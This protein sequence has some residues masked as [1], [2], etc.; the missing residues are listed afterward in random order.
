LKQGAKLGEVP[1]VKRRYRTA[2]F[3]DLEKRYE[4]RATATAGSLEAVAILVAAGVG[5]GILPSHYV[6]ALPHAVFEVVPASATPLTT[7]FYVL[8]RADAGEAPIVA[9][10]VRILGD[11]GSDPAAP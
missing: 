5:I 7:S 10:F 4:L 3:E 9:E 2:V 11:F 6:D 1:Y 8:H